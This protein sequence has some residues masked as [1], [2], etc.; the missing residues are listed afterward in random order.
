MHV[1]F[2]LAAFDLRLPGLAVE[3]RARR[4]ALGVLGGNGE[5]YV[6]RNARD[7]AEIG[8]IRL[9]PVLE[10]DGLPDALD[11][12]VALLAV[13]LRLAAVILGADF[14]EVVAVLPDR[15]HVQFKVG[16]AAL[17]AA[18][19]HAVD[20]YIRTVVHRAEAKEHAALRGE[21]HAA[22]IPADARDVLFNL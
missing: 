4:R 22:A 7:E 3:V 21:T 14:D 13:G 17:M 15:G 9:R 19:A 8:N 18:H 20:V 1:D 12:A 16:I 6:A 5:L 10:P 11:F 2:S